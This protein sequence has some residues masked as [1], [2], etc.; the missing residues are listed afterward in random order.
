MLLRVE[1]GSAQLSLEIFPCL[2]Q[3]TG[4][5]HWPKLLAGLQ[6][7]FPKTKSKVTQTGWSMQKDQKDPPYITGRKFVSCEFHEEERQ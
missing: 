5:S 2:W 1:K 3:F 7:P 4:W 6:K